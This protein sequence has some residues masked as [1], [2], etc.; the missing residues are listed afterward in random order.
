MTIGFYQFYL[1]L[2]NDYQFVAG[3]IRFLLDDYRFLSG[4]FFS[5]LVWILLNFVLIFILPFIQFWYFHLQSNF[6]ILFFTLDI[7]YQQ[8]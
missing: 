2:L 4:F 5:V 8:F 3:F 1:F 6:Y 7:N